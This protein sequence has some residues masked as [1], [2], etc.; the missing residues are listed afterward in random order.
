LKRQ[1]EQAVDAAAAAPAKR[2]RE[3]ADAESRA[4]VESPTSALP[5]ASASA[6]RL[7][8]LCDDCLAEVCSFLQPRQELWAL[9]RCSRRLSRFIGGEG[10]FRPVAIEGDSAT[11]EAL[12]ANYG[13]SVERVRVLRRGPRR[14]GGPELR[15]MRKLLQRPLRELSFPL[16]S[17]G[18]DEGAWLS[19]QASLRSLALP[20]VRAQDEGAL[21]QRLGDLGTRA[22]G[23]VRLELSDCQLSDATLAAV[24][25]RMPRLRYL[26]LSRTGAADSVAGALSSL[27]Q[28]L[29]LDV[30]FCAHFGASMASAPVGLRELDALGTPF[31][32]QQ[33]RVEELAARCKRLRVLKL[34]CMVGV[35]SDVCDS[36]ITALR[37]LREL[38][39]L[40]LFGYRALSRDALAGLSEGFAHLHELRV[41]LFQEPSPRA[42]A[43][44][45][46]LPALREARLTG[47][48]EEADAADADHKDGAAYSTRM[49]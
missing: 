36:V 2:A 35:C 37:P 31:A 29:E 12:L 25:A 19:A 21:L 11:L 20:L 18:D 4:R 28:L 39:T 30:S 10:G 5:A 43:A 41:R 6:S 49:M 14:E 38:E 46:A 7:E 32:A 45:R 34:S 33:R 8:A 13:G 15:A 47:V 24:L 16:L 22:T 1:R 40:W 17:V 3:A 27:P 48:L 23:L 9:A 44:L 42:A 26:N